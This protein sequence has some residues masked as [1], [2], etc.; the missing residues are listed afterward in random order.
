MLLSKYKGI[1]TLSSTLTSQSHDLQ[2]FLRS[3]LSKY[4]II[5]TKEPVSTFSKQYGVLIVP[6]DS[7]TTHSTPN[8]L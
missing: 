4:I 1:G 8:N 3:A 7:P 2:S 6:F 5:N